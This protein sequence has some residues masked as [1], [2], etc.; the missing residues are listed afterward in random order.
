MGTGVAGADYAGSPTQV[1][2]QS[3]T[4]HQFIDGL[5]ESHRHL[6]E[7]TA[8]DGLYETTLTVPR[9]A[10]GG[11]WQL[12]EFQLVDQV[13]NTRRLSPREL[14]HDGLPTSFSVETR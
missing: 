7:G 5:F 2:F 4:A 6:V 1:R 8:L 14:Q 11:E 10:E 12:T 9:Q 13:G 3:P